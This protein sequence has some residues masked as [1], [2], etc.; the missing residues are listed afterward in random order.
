MRAMNPFLTALALLALGCASRL[1]AAERP[2]VLLIVA[3]DND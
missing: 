1:T 3:D 2:N